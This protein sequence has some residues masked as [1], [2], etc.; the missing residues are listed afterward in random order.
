MAKNRIL[1]CVLLI[2]SFSSE[3]I[4]QENRYV[5]Y[6][7][8]KANTVYTTDAPEAYLS[9]RSI[10]R[11]T[12]QGLSITE[13]D[14][15]V[16]QAYVSAIGA[17]GANPIFSSKW[18]NAVIIEANAEQL[19]AIRALP[20]YLKEEYAAPG[21]VPTAREKGKMKFSSPLRIAKKSNTSQLQNEM[22]GIPA[23]HAQGFTGEDM[24]IGVF[25]GGF[26]NVNS[27]AFFSHIFTNQRLIGAYD[28]VHNQP[29]VFD[30]NDHGTQ[31]LSCIGAYEEDV[32]VGTAY[33]AS[34]VLCVTEDVRSEYRIEEYNW[35][36]AA[37][38]ADSIGVDIIST[39]L[40][41]NTFGDASMNYVYE[42]LD[43]KTAIITQAANFAA[44]KGILL[45]NSAGNEGNKSWKYITP[46]A[47]GLLNVAVG[48][49]NTNYTIAN[50]SSR[51]PTAD[52]RIKPDVVALGSPAIVGKSDGNIGQ[53]YGTSF[54]A[55]LIT[56]L[57]AGLWQANPTLSAA[58]II[59]KLLLSGS[60]VDKPD[61]IY[62]FGIPHFER[63][64]GQI[65]SGFEDK[66]QGRFQIFPNPIKDGS[67][68]IKATGFN[69]QMLEVSIRDIKG[70]LVNSQSYAIDG[71]SDTFS[72]PMSTLPSGV[73]YVFIA[74]DGISENIR[75]IKE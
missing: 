13:N 6:L 25:D 69:Y 24:L 5:I 28:F 45:V 18:F 37:E 58:A 43:G 31:V 59:D 19:S 63:A 1:G 72:L 16:N 23:M 51:G 74:G 73:Y 42:D 50:F 75:L 64:Q 8:D 65:I 35:L 60:M 55:P 54:A 14:F 2:L 9:P 47:D 3:L 21:I 48:A 10:K 62:G 33:N 67:F 11:R 34:F 20:S 52:G 56:G 61:T 44:S 26:I 40:G 36:V 39:S 49:I 30:F 68:Y 32:L 70:G 12:T 22:L 53:A 57:A 46:P 4:G 15:P 41:Y 27:I 17:T 71:E 38:Y 29:N 66:L 7:K